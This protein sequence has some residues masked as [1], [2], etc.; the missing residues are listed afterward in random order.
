MNDKTPL[1]SKTIS[2]RLRERYPQPR[3]KIAGPAQDDRDLIHEAADE[4]ERLRSAMIRAYGIWSQFQGD[5]CMAS[6]GMADVLNDALSGDGSQVETSGSDLNRLASAFYKRVAYRVPGLID[7]IQDVAKPL[8]VALG[9]EGSPEET[10]R[11]DCPVKMFPAGNHS[12]ACAAH[13]GKRC[14][15]HLSQKAP[16][17]DDCYRHGPGTFPQSDGC[18]CAKCAP[19]GSA[20]EEKNNGN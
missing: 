8:R 10:G 3:V 15:C 20:N 14:D 17:D 13:D 2:Q 6:N 11:D 5:T 7:Q 19:N 9:M 18:L 16:D 1:T 4:I 12:P